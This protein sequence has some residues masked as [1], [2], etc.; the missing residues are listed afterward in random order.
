MSVMDFD[1]LYAK[2]AAA[3]SSER[4]YVNGHAVASRD[5]L[6]NEISAFYCGCLDEGMSYEDIS[7]MADDNGCIILGLT[8]PELEYLYDLLIDS[9]A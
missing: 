1:S 2:Y 8:Q 5:D 4:R 6:A 7:D 3:V 9:E